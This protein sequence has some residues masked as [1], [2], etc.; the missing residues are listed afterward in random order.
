MRRGA[1]W[2]CVC[3]PVV[4]L[5]RAVH[6]RVLLFPWLHEPDSGA[7]PKGSLLL[8]GHVSACTVCKVCVVLCVLGRAAVDSNAI[9]VE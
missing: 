7:L 4:A 6:S 3:C 2:S 5:Q 9:V 1:V 8:A